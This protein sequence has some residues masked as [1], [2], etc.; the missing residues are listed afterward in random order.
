MRVLVALIRVSTSVPPSSCLISHQFF[1]HLDTSIMSS[2]EDRD[3]LR[4]ISDRLQAP[5]STSEGLVI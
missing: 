4:L 3:L 1:Q 2:A 5:I